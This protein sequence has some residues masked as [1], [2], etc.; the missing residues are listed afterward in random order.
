MCEWRLRLT[1]VDE[2]AV[3]L[4]AA[5]FPQF[6]FTGTAK[7]LRARGAEFDA[8]GVTKLV[9][10]PAGP[11]IAGELGRMMAAVGDSAS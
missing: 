3:G 6:T 9:Y 11:D 2:E 4:A 5:C 10:Q 8:E 1:A 7:Q